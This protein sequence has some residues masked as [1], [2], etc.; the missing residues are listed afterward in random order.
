MIIFFAGITSCKKPLNDYFPDLF[1]T[2]KKNKK[3]VDNVVETKEIE[4]NKEIA[5]KNKVKIIL[6]EVP[7]FSLAHLK[8]YLNKLIMYYKYDFLSPLI[9]RDKRQF[10]FSQIALKNG[11]PQELL[12]YHE[13]TPH[14]NFNINKYQQQTFNFDKK[15]VKEDIG[16]LPELFKGEFE[17]LNSKWTMHKK[18]KWY[19]MKIIGVKNYKDTYFKEF[20][21]W[22]ANILGN[23]TSYDELKEISVNK[24]I[25][26]KNDEELLKLILED[27]SL[28]AAFCASTGKKYKTVNMYWDKVY[29]ELSN[30]ERMDIIKKVVKIGFT[31]NDLFILSMSEI[32]NINI[33]TIHRAKYGKTT[34]KVVRGDV[35]DLILSSTFYKAPT[36]NYL[37]RPI[38]FFNKN[39]DG[40]SSSYELIVDSSTPISFKSLYMKLSDL[41]LDLMNLIKGHIEN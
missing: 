38:L 1:K 16:K 22:F 23:K 36:E 34:E 6:E 24:L 21:E 41:P 9:K 5:L 33:I 14:N 11:I 3:E 8:N 13:S 27:S 10:T 28:F 40:I 37:N 17:D 2:Q 20:F 18:S 29:D 7:I 4:N 19:Y 12:I 26:I 32:L 31:T 15:I 30:K 39:D 35:E 25:K